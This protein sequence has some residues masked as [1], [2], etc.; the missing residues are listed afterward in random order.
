MLCA[1]ASLFYMETPPSSANATASS[2]DALKYFLIRHECGASSD[3]YNWEA[4]RGPEFAS[5]ILADHGL[6]VAIK[7]SSLVSFL[8]H[9]HRG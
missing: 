8:Q 5:R 6:P 7:V 9:V 4:Y 3:R 1:G 2:A